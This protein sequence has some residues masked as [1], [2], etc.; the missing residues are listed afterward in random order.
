MVKS[1]RFVF[2][3]QF[4]G[5]PKE[6]DFQLVEEETPELKDGEILVES[7]FNS[8]DPYMRPYTRRLPTGIT[9]IGEGCGRVIESKSSDFPVGTVVMHRYGWC[10]HAVLD[11]KN[12][13]PQNIIRKAPADYPKDL[14]L[15]LLLGAV[16]MPGMTA[17]FGLL[18]LCEPKEGETVFVNGAAGA[19]GS[20]VGQIAKIK[21]CKAVGSAGSDAKVAWL[22][23]LGFDAAFNYKTVSSLDAALKE[24]APNGIDCYFDNVGADFSST[25]LN[26]MNLFGRV[27]ICGSISTYND[28][29]PAKGP[30][31]FVTI[32]SKQLTVTGFI[33]TRWIKEWPKGMEQMVQWIKEGKI[34]YREHVTEGF[35][36]MPKAFIGMLVGENT[37]KAVVKL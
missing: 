1:K 22:K 16:G 8:V 20:L 15:S 26:H 23:E 10:T 32:L 35:E 4:E 9:M 14:P 33:V 30:Y 12:K 37:G 7:L 6:S 29:E 28:N 31:P 17:Y 36:N 5:L 34:K 2:A 18:K 13:D 27:S 19:V 24:A 25:V 21:G 11:T 3:R